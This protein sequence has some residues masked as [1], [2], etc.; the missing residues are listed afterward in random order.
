MKA[1]DS[2]ASLAQSTT[3]GIERRI[4]D[5]N[6]RYAQCLDG[7]RLADWPDF[8]DDDCR[9]LI[10]S[11]ENLDLGMEA[12]WLRFENKRM[13][14]DR[15]VSLCEVNIYQIHY[16]RRL[17][18]NVMVTGREGEIWLARA[19][20]MLVHTTN[21]GRSHIFSVGEYRDRIVETAGALKF[22]ERLVVVDTFTVPSHL[23]MPI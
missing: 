2:A 23:S 21:E 11:R 22:T 9:Y 1:I 20:Y 16:E 3:P 17:V 13:L 6:F 14:R 10:H 4:E 7:N 5:L 8:F 18:S 19:N 12:Y 15:V